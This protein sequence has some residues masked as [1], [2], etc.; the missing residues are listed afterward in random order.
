MSDSIGEN[1]RIV[2]TELSRLDDG[3]TNYVSARDL[4]AITNLSPQ[5]I[6]DAVTLLVRDGFVEWVQ[7][8]GTGPFDFLD[9]TT[10]ALGRYEIE[11]MRQSSI[12]IDTEE[13]GNIPPTVP[14]GSPYG[15]TE[16]HWRTVATRKSNT[17]VLYVVFGHQ[18]SSEYYD[19]SS[20][21]ENIE[22]M[23]QNAVDTYN[24]QM[25][26]SRIELDFV[27]LAAGYGEHLFN[28]IAR[29]IIAADIAIF[30]TSDLNPNVMLEMGVALTWGVKVLPIKR[31]DRPSPPSDI[32]GQTWVNY[33]N[34]G[35][36]FTDREHQN[37]LVS[38]ISRVA[39]R[40]V[41]A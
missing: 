13:T 34:N 18:F 36:I 8:L 12:D 41:E 16:D 11:R 10:T 22:L 31:E 37:K 9:V 33:Q 20:I 25:M 39:R 2:L 6:N 21:R 23:M 32:S 27:S 28:E 5:Q 30:E 38:L 7:T 1:K 24:G 15:F 29:D 17:A 3:G 4:Q 19:T 14:I 40:K 26:S 35:E